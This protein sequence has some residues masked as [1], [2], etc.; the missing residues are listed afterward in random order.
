MRRPTHEE[1]QSEMSQAG[2]ASAGLIRRSLCFSLPAH[3][4]TL[5]APPTLLKTHRT[6]CG[7]RLGGGRL[8]GGR[9]G[10]GRLGGGRL[11]VQPRHET[12]ATRDEEGQHLHDLQKLLPASGCICRVLQAIGEMGFFSWL[13][14]GAYDPKRVKKRQPISG[15]SNHSWTESIMFCRGN[16]L[17]GIS[18]LRVIQKMAG[19]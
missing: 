8:S 2:K 1:I 5:I 18:R 7:G 4:K 11:A 3:R 6:Q 13:S 14:D 17:V 10:G 19:P 12:T 15:T 9:L 16:H